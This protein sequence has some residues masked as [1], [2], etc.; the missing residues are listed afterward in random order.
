MWESRVGVGRGH[1]AWVVGEGNEKR[2]SGVGGGKGTSEEDD[3]SSLVS[4]Q[5]SDPCKSVS[6]KMS[7]RTR[8][9]LSQ[10]SLNSGTITSSQDDRLGASH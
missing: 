8:L 7:F 9:S 5:V 4:H 2:A 3:S 6:V 10:L 1:Q